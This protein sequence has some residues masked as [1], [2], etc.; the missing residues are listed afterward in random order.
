MGTEKV[1][2][3]EVADKQTSRICS[4][5]SRPHVCR[6]SAPGRSDM[7][8]TTCYITRSRVRQDTTLGST[9]RFLRRCR[10][11]LLPATLS[12][13]SCRD[14]V[15]VTRQSSRADGRNHIPMATE[16][17][18]WLVSNRPYG[19][20]SILMEARSCHRPALQGF[21]SGRSGGLGVKSDMDCMRDVGPR[22]RFLILRCRLFLSKNSWEVGFLVDTR[23]RRAWYWLGAGD[24]PWP[25]WLSNRTGG[26]NDGV[27]VAVV[28]MI[29]A[30]L[31]E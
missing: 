12:V 24:T 25:P 17:R 27:Y 11:I 19:T 20:L 30:C 3:A 10:V 5:G 7:G 2:V 31:L 13:V 22:G 26:S 18:A 23:G 29:A 21:D 16:G 6:S 8:L 1:W 28:D 15:A 9:T 4:S 14:W